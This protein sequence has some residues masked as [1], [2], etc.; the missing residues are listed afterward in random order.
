MYASVGAGRTCVE[1]S[2]RVRTRVRASEG[3]CMRVRL[4]VRALVG[5]CVGAH[6]GTV[7]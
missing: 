3:A 2:T 6:A 7:A 1:G 5:A 4:H